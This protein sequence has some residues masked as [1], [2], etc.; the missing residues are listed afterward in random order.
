MP[1]V[2]IHMNNDTPVEAEIQNYETSGEW[3]EHPNLLLS[4]GASANPHV[5]ALKSIKPQCM[6]KINCYSLTL[7]EMTQYIRNYI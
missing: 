1:D 6:V 7:K 4:N 3:I 5:S 2:D